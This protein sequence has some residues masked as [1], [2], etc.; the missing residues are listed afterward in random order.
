MTSQEKI[1]SYVEKF[2]RLTE[3]E[4]IEFTKRFK[5]TRIKKRQFIVQPGFVPKCR[6]FVIKGA[7]RAYVIGDEGKDHTI[8]F[9]MEDWW[10][11]DFNS[12]INQQPAS[13]FVVALEDCILLQISFE[14]EQTLKALNHKFETFFRYKAELSTAFMQSRIITNLTKSAKE[15]YD[16]FIKGHPKLAQR[17]PQYALASYLG[18][19]TQFLSKIRNQKP[20]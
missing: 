2:V 19:T 11:S 3:K 10:I 7:L 18:I 14:D 20:E 5:E 17:V 9:A 8:Q 12:Y 4:K 16:L 15:R 13:M 6:Y 1:T